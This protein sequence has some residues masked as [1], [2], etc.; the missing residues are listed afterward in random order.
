[1]SKLA[2]EDRSAAFGG[3]T[4]FQYN[5]WLSCPIGCELIDYRLI[6]SSEDVPHFSSTS[7]T[8]FTFL[9]RIVLI[10]YGSQRMSYLMWRL[11]RGFLTWVGTSFG[12]EEAGVRC[13]PPS[14]VRPP[15]A[16]SPSPDGSDGE[17]DE[18]LA[19]QG[20]EHISFP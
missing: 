1:M 4:Q 18:E 14:P 10:F 19:L 3:N 5:I 2:R 11:V 9:F 8:V 6:S 16:C 13:L 12:E 15:A 7:E 17:S 20:A